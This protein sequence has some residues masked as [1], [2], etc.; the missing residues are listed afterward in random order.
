MM[1]GDDRRFCRS[2]ERF[3]F[4]LL[5]LAFEPVV[6]QSVLSILSLYDLTRHTHTYIHI[7]THAYK[8]ETA[9]S[10]QK[11]QFVSKLMLFKF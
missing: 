10:G 9:S 3:M 11:V 1:Q 2:D 5:L 6:C 7:Q 4:Q 8:L